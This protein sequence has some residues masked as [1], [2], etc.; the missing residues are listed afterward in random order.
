MGANLLVAQSGGPS[1]AINATVS[2]V[3][4]F[5]LISNNI[6]KVLGAV[7]GIQGVLNENFIELCDT[8]S[9]PRNMQLLCQTP[10][11]ALGSCR[12]KLADVDKDAEL[13]EKIINIFRKHNIGYFVY[14]GGNDSM[15]TV[16]KLSLYIEQKGIDDIKVMG[17][18]KTIDN[19]LSLTDHCPGFGSA[20]KYIATTF[21][22]L[23][24]DRAVYNDQ[25]ITVVEVMGRN[26]GWLTAASILAKENG[27]NGPQLIYLC[28][29]P[30]SKEKFIED[31]KREMAK[32]LHVI[33]AV[34][35]G[36]KDEQ[37]R[38]LSESVQSG[39][40]DVFG[41]K[42]I[43]GVANVL[44]DIIRENIAGAKVR[45]IELNLMQR[46][47]ARNA[48]LTDIYES[49]M[50]GQKAAACAVEGKTG[51]MASVERVSNEPYKVRYVDVDVA[52]VANLEKTVPLE[53]ITEDGCQV[54]NEMLEYLR[55]L[56]QGE[57]NM[58][59]I[60]GTP[61]HIRLY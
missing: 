43:S 47:S 19:D 21:T 12:L 51:R 8:L 36:V 24:R 28:E 57:V 33:I 55:P 31:V 27:G 23:E 52:Q 59:F 29:K 41:H 32:S 6:E 45:A 53:W 4:E 39:D 58:T 1:A 26:A 56:I 38:Y 22:E 16:R 40:E 61:E 54:T 2:G 18:P 37:G 13:Y 3:A 25:S 7:N 48:S 49:R 10:A 44:G 30:L 15:D 50:L 34:S 5:G 20:A 17:A 11:A 46:C 42:Y 9:S 14:I 35:E 60:N